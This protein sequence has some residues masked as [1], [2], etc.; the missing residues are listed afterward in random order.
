MFTLV[1]AILLHKHIMIF[2][3]SAALNKFW[4]LLKYWIFI[5]DYCLRKDIA[6]KIYIRFCKYRSDECHFYRQLKL[7]KMKNHT[8][9]FFCRL[10][11][12]PTFL[13]TTFKKLP[14]YYMMERNKI[15][16]L[17]IESLCKPQRKHFNT[18]ASLK[19]FEKKSY[20]NTYL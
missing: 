1:G 14:I 6:E 11:H 20:R 5:I 18:C 9:K 10:N 7:T 13:Y 12:P 19:K 8:I 15:F 3:F 2:Q 4:T 16:L 17:K